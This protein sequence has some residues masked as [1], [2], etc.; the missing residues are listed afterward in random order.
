MARS[1]ILHKLAS[2]AL[3][4]SLINPPTARERR[5]RPSI[6]SPSRHLGPNHHD[7]S[8]NTY[9]V[10]AGQTL[11]TTAA[12]GSSCQRC[13]SDGRDTYASLVSSTAH[14]TLTLSSNG[15]V[16]YTPNSGFTGTDTFT[17]QTKDG[18]LTSPTTTV[19]INV[20][21]TSSITAKA[22]NYTVAAPA[23]L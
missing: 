21:P 11:N 14:G 15:S 5:R 6:T 12:N 2:P 18:S 17:Y 8:R 7:V 16:A 22:E 4:R 9:T 19:T 23:M 20:D 3:I 13:R 10:F 1:P